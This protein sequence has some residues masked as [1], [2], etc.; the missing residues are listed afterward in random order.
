MDFVA[1]QVF[2]AV[3]AEGGIS[4]AA[5]KLHRVQSNVSVRIQKLEASL[6]TAL[7]IR[8]KRRLVLSAAGEQFLGYA[9]RILRLS[10]QAR[11]AALGGVPGGVMRLGTLES[12]AASR[13]PPLLSRYHALHPGVRLELAT[14]TT[15]ALIAAVMKRELDAAFVAD[16]PVTNEL[17]QLPAFTEELA[18]L[19]PTSHPRIRR[20]RDVGDA[21][22][23]S[24][25]E[26]CAYRRRLL[27]WLAADHVWP[28]KLLELGSYHSIVACVAAGTGIAFVPRS[29]LDTLRIA[30]EIATYALP[31]GLGHTVTALVWRR[32]EPSLALHA[33]QEAVAES[34][35]GRTARPPARQPAHRA[36]NR[37]VHA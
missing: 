36:R 23:I 14:G 13:L 33:M 18:I 27:A 25:P 22:I 7:F 15:D 6:G 35:G 4:A 11:E 20:A 37:R 16:P 24:F 29:V 9:E 26:G 17:E 32:G 8:E 10:E 3:A 1:L 31:K 12:T 19:A 30:D 34:K 2:Q 5:R 21:T 28:D